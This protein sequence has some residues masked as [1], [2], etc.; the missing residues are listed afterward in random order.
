[1]ADV[2]LIDALLLVGALPWIW[3]WALLAAIA[4]LTVKTAVVAALVWLARADAKAA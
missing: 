3:H 4:L 2:L 1:M